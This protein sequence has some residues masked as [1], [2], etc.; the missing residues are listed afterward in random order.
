MFKF[1]S[2]LSILII[3]P[4]LC[5]ADNLTQNAIQHDNELNIAY[6]NVIKLLNETQESQIRHAQLI[7]IKY[8][9]ANCEFENN[10][11]NKRHWIEED[12]SNFITLECISRLSL[13]R[14]K[15]LNKYYELVGGESKGYV[16]VS[17]KV[18]ERGIAEDVKVVESTADEKYS[19]KSI[20]RVLT[21][22]YPKNIVDGV[23]IQ[24]ISRVRFDVAS[25]K[26]RKLAKP[27]IP[28]N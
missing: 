3:S 27:L 20:M 9:D 11:P 7:W 12:I 8:R 22:I 19:K 13:A 25:F 17:F 14:T 16:I 15:E 23:H 6:K 28:P 1:R 26:K 5:L 10:L 4:C 21:G 2:L 24:K 18:N